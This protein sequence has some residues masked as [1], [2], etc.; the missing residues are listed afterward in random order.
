MSTA[1]P[2]F[3][4]KALAR[5][6]LNWLLVFV[7]VVVVLELTHGPAGWIFVTSCLAI[8]PLA[9]WMGRATE[10]L[11][12]RTGEGIGGLLNATFG[13]AAE[14]IIG[15]MALRAGLYDVVKASLTGSI[16]GN[17]LLVLG[18]SFLAGGVR[19]P[20]QTFNATAS[21]MGATMLTLAAIGL[22]IP[23][24]FLTMLHGSQAREIQ[25]SLAIAIILMITYGIS[26]IF[27]LLT[28]R[29]LFSGK[30][31]D[32]EANET[33]EPVWSLGR[34]VGVLLLAAAAVAVISEF[35]VGAIEET[36]HAWGLT[37]VFIGVV[38]V[39]IVG[40]AAEHSSA[41]LM[42]MKDKMDLS[43]NIALGSSLQIAYF[44]A[45]ILVFLSYAC[46][47]PMDLAFTPAEVLAVVL[48][49][50]IV[51]Q[52]ASDG[53][54]NWFEGVQLLSVYLILALVFYFLP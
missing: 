21:S 28:H 42:A 46:G 34:S 27:S 14:L 3:A 49:V 32:Q 41:I 33:D 40:N 1:R 20:R 48:S 4:W 16:I 17:N 2:S 36:T 30:A 31:A 22:V 47:K 23:H 7:P 54:S 37:Q 44:V 6:S 13:N 11:A 18:A 15:I 51:G 50:V 38:I 26:L 29:H 24:S 45:P 43:L 10:H 39:A 53:E 5:P 19:F 35:L 9:G 12:H 52:A 8:I 25:L